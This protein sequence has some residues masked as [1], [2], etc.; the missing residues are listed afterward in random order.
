MRRC[1]WAGVPEASIVSDRSELNYARQR[2]KN[3]RER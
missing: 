2:W 1:G 3:S